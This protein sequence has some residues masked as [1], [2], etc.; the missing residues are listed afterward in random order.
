MLVFQFPQFSCSIHISP[1]LISSLGNYF[2]LLLVSKLEMR[3]TADAA[4]QLSFHYK[5]VSEE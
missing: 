3:Q 2:L 1:L 4:S 5:S